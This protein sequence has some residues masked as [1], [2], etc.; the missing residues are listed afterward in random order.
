[1]KPRTDL[2]QQKLRLSALY[3]FVVDRIG[4]QSETI[5]FVKA[6]VLLSHIKKR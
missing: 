1:M 4:T 3:L 5:G 6:I 2:D